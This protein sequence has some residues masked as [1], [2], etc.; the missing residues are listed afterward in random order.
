MIPDYQTIMLPLL[1]RTSDGKEHKMREI[2]DTL[3]KEFSLSD[4]DLNVLISN[5]TQSIFYNRVSWAKTYLKKAC[6]VENVG[7]GTIRITKRGR[8]VL[9]K[10][11]KNIDIKM[12]NK[13]EEFVNFRSRT[14]SQKETEQEITSTDTSNQTPEELIDSAYQDFQKSLATE[15]LD[16]IRNVSPAFFEKLVVSLLVK[17][18]YGGSVK[19]AGKAI[20]KTGDEGIDGIIKEDKLGLDVI[21]IQAKR[22]KENN[23]IGRPEI[24]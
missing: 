11:P 17:M 13:F 22:W 8:E 18:G 4:E 10:N 15:L 16:N 7:K 14:T 3:A 9:N 6:L 5:G 23:I 24:Q 2:T 20:G 12:L 21:Y 1:K 19:D